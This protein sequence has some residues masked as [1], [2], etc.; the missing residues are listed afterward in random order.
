VRARRK[1]AGLQARLVAQRAEVAQEG[2][3]L[4]VSPGRLG[5]AGMRHE[6]SRSPYPPIITGIVDHRYSEA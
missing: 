2:S 3:L 4:C 1:I 6:P 5:V